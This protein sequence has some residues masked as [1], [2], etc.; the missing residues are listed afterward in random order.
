MSK[1]SLAGKFKTKPGKREEMI[2]ILTEAANGMADVKGCHLYIVHKDAKDENA[3]WVY[4]LW[5]TKEDHDAS[6]KLPGTPEM[7]AKAMPLIDGK[8]EDNELEA[9]SGKGY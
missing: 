8:P 1:Y 2:D 6:L 9:V 7:I 5:D 3:V 4:E